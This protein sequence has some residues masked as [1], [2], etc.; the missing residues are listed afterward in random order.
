MSCEEPTLKIAQSWIARR[1]SA[2]VL[3]SVILK[4]F[5]ESL[6]LKTLMGRID[7]ISMMASLR[8]TESQRRRKMI[9]YF[10]Q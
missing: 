7:L 1:V 6:W 2:S 5:P 3:V 9:S 10:L 8:G 4:T